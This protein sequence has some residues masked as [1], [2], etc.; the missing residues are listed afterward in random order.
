MGSRSGAWKPAAKQTNVP[1]TVSGEEAGK[2][3]DKLLLLQKIIPEGEVRQ[4]LEELHLEESRPCVL[5]AEVTFWIVLLMGLVPSVAYE[6]L[7]EA[8]RRLVGGEKTPGRSAICQSRARLGI[9]PP[10]L[11]FER[12]CRVA[13]TFQTPGAFYKGW[14]L[15]AIDGTIYTA[16]DSDANASAFGYPE[17]GRSRGAFPQVR[18]LSLVETGTHLEVALTIKGIREKDSGERSMVPALLKHIKSGMLLLW[19]RGFF[20]YKLYQE[21]MLRGQILAR[22]SSRLILQPIEELR[23]GSYI[24]KVYPSP[25]ERCKDRYGI[26][27]RVIRYRLNDQQR[28]GHQEEHVLLTTLHDAKHY[29]ALEL[30]ELY[31]KRWQIEE[32]FDE[33]KTHQTG[34]TV[35]KPTHLR[36]R[37]P[38]GVMQEIY[39]LAIDHYAIRRVMLEAADY[40]GAAPTDLSFVGCLE[41]I[42]HHMAECPTDPMSWQAWRLALLQRLASKRIVKQPNRVNP[43]VVRTKMSKFKKKRPEHR[44]IKPVDK[45]FVATVEMRTP[46]CGQSPSQRGYGNKSSAPTP[47]ASCLYDH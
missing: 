16:P 9:A 33:Q 39:A 2:V 13:A 45:D 8:A 11:L 19:D 36:S 44:G 47:V 42:R 35:V 14:R 20:S 43:R 38:L 15:M 10:R 4:L 31:H 28:V 24:A 27:T 30:I 21:F 5:N 29:P 37:T 17:G 23:D 46:C 1:K 41:V 7:F 26:R 40:A 3:L 32:V 6:N 18:K 22:V 12:T 34:K 25:A